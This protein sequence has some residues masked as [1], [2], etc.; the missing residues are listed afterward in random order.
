M[1]TA[2]MKL[3]DAY[4]VKK[5]YNKPRKYIKKQSYHFADKVKAMVLSVVV[6]GCELS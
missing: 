3:K 6:Y 2:A 5:S 4:Y 1:V